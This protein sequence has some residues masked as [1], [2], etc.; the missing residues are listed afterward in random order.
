[1]P[2]LGREGLELELEEKRK[3]LRRTGSIREG[4][5]ELVEGG[6]R[7]PAAYRLS[8]MGKTHGGVARII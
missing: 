2:P 4:G 7:K 5:L 8:Y 3:S 6:A 1:M